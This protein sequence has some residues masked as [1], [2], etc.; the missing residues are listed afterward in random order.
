[1]HIGTC[2][3][4]DTPR[5][6]CARPHPPGLAELAL[7]R[8]VWD[9]YL[10]CAPSES[11]RY[12]KLEHCDIGR[13]QQEDIVEEAGWIVPRISEVCQ[14]PMDPR[15]SNCHHDKCGNLKHL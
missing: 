3:Q 9:L 10:P 12:R 2:S 13:G 14:R 8:S 7:Q 11:G 1:M 5:K 15:R 6:T 4:A